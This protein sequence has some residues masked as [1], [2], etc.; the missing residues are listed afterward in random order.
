MPVP[1]S[2]AMDDDSVYIAC[3]RMDEYLGKLEQL[4]QV[5]QTMQARKRS[6]SSISAKF[7]STL[8]M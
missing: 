4:F 8:H 6:L 1:S 2:I 3:R 7:S 5:S